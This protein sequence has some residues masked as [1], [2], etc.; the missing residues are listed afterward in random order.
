M[1]VETGEGL[2]DADSLCSVAFADAYHVA[3]GN[4]A[5]A[6][7]INA[8]KEAALIKATLYLE[9][10]YSGRWIERRVHEL[11]AL[12]WPRCYVVDVD[13]FALGSDVVPKQVKQAVAEVAL[14]VVNGD[15][16]LP[17]VAT[18]D[19]NVVSE[20]VSVG[21]I[22]TSTTYSGKKATKKRYEVVESLLR[23]WLSP[24]HQIWRA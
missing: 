22:S 6:A 9:T 16:L 7:A 14:R 3:Q 8:T 11:Q 1:I 2:A 17:D 18:A 15:T 19:A 4:I 10:M 23:T 21:P 5:W 12:A 20:S 13:G 24:R